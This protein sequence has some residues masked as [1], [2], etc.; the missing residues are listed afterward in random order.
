LFGPYV[1]HPLTRVTQSLGSTMMKPN[2]TSNDINHIHYNILLTRFDHTDL[3]P[4]IHFRV[5]ESHIFIP[6]SQV[7]EFDEK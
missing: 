7:V 3:I 2:Y 4:H 5:V 6:L 1:L